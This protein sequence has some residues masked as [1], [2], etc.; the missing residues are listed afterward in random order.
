MMFDKHAISPLHQQDKTPGQPMEDRADQ[1]AISRFTR[2][3]FLG[4]VSM[5]GI[6]TSGVPFLPS[7]RAEAV[8]TPAATAA[9]ETPGAMPMVLMVNSR[10]HRVQLEPRVTL[11]D[12][13]REHLN[14]FGTK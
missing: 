12:A 5:A 4:G 7:A 10:E 8:E 1:L 11:L 9:V 3:A 6:A 2:R 13:L 14:L